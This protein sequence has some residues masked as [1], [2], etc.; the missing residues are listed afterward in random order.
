MSTY[1][2]PVRLG[3]SAV[4]TQPPNVDPRRETDEHTGKLEKEVAERDE[5]IRELEK[6]LLEKEMADKDDQIRELEKRLLEKEVAERDNRVRELEKR[7]ADEKARVAN[8]ESVRVELGVPVQPLHL[9]APAP[10]VMSPSPAPARETSP[11]APLKIHAARYGWARNAWTK[12][13]GYGEAN[14]N[15][16]E[17]HIHP[18]H[19]RPGTLRIFLY[20]DPVFSTSDDLKRVESESESASPSRPRVK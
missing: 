1:Y 5:R 12:T 17:P 3:G 18:P 19:A 11:A 6:R 15:R 4:P 10:Q 7:L 20:P 13:P 16:K 8:V 9:G 2:P 14:P